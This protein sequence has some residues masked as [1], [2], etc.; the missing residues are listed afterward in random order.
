VHVNNKVGDTPRNENN[1]HIRLDAEVT[2]AKETRKL[3]IEIGDFIA[4]DSGF[5]FTDTG[6][7]KSHFLDDKAGCA[8]IIKAMLDLGASALKKLPVMF[9]FSNFEEVGHGACAGFPESIN[10]LLVVDMGV[11]GTG[12][13]GDEYSVSICVKDSSGPYDYELRQKLVKLARDN[14]IRFKPDVFPFYGSDGSSALRAGLDARVGLIGP[15]VSA[16]HGNE[17]T[18]LKGM[19]AT[20]DLLMQ[21]LQQI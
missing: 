6:F 19:Q 5:E 13:A 14:K 8:A 3:G 17:R 7:I 16:S 10:E 1:M 11:V 15:G 20:C 21:Y 18:H 12:V 9:F 4:F 2:N